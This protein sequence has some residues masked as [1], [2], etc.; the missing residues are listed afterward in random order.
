MQISVVGQ[1]RI[2]VGNNNYKL[3]PCVILPTYIRW[4]CRACNHTAEL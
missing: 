1:E 3:K 4:I 2:N